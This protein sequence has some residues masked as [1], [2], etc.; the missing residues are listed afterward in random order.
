MGNRY[1]EEN[2]HDDM[3]SEFPISSL[4]DSRPSPQTTQDLNV[5]GAGGEIDD[6]DE[7]SRNGVRIRDVSVRS[8]RLFAVKV[9]Q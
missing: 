3:F 9:N 2:D 5:L 8:S 7:R 6:G 1:F 4:F